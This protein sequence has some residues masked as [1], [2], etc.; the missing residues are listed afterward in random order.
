MR[1]LITYLC[2]YIIFINT[3][4]ICLIVIVNPISCRTKTGNINRKNIIKIKNAIKIK[5]SAPNDLGILKFSI[6]SVIGSKKYANKKP[7]IKGLKISL[8]KYKPK[9]KTEAERKQ[10]NSSLADI[11]NIFSP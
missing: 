7:I 11:F 1:S 5:N 6:L 4:G 10:K 2:R 8:K 3:Q 9:I